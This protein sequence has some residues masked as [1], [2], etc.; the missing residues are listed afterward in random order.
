MG[1]KTVFGV[2][3]LVALLAALVAGSAWAQGMGTQTLQLTPSR[4]S[5]VS[6]T[7]TLTDTSGGVQV[8]LQVQ[9]LPTANGTEHIAHIHSGATCADDRAGA[10]GPVEFPLQSVIAQG[11]AGTSTTVIPGVTL[12]TLF[13]GT[14][15]YV[16]VHAQMTGAGTPPGIACADLAMTTVPSTGGFVSPL[17]ALLLG[18]AA[19]VALVTT[20]GLLARRRV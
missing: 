11:G 20:A 3:L 5:G 9:G 19:L 10:G 12:A 4:G 16:N 1:K 15:R 17:T 7:A 2:A 6:G 14:P 18:G 8:T 13:D